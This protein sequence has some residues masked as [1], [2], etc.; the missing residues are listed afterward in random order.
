[1]SK[2]EFVK[3]VMKALKIL[4]QALQ[5]LSVYEGY[6]SPSV[7]R[8]THE[9]TSVLSS[10]KEYMAHFLQLSESE[11]Y[12]LPSLEKVLNSRSHV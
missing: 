3:N 2:F 7:L 8:L 9:V 1:M 5:T 11:T 12:P 4:Q 10:L 6:N